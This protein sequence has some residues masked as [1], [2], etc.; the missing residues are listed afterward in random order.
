M[1]KLTTFL[2]TAFVCISAAFADI[3]IKVDI[4]D[5]NLGWN[6]VF[7][8]VG[9]TDKK[10]GDYFTPEPVEG[11]D[12][13]YSYTFTD[14]DVLTNLCFLDDK[15]LWIGSPAASRPHC[16]YFISEVVKST[17]YVVGHAAAPTA[18]RTCEEIDCGLPAEPKA[19]ITAPAKATVNKEITL[20]ATSADVTEPVYT[21]YVKTPEAEDFTALAA[22]TYTPAVTGTYTFKV[23]V[24]EVGASETILATSKE[25][26]V[27]VE[28]STDIVVTVDASVVGWSQVY[29]YRWVVGGGPGSFVEPENLGNG[30]Y[31]YTFTGNTEVGLVF[32]DNNTWAADSRQTVDVVGGITAGEHCFLINTAMSGGKRTVTKISCGEGPGVVLTLPAKIFEGDNL[33]LTANATNVDNPV[34]TYS[35]KA[36]GAADF[37]ALDGDSY[38]VAQTGSYTF[39]VA[40]AD[41]SAPSTIL[42]TEE[43]EVTVKEL[44]APITVT[45]DIS[46]VGW[47]DVHIYWWGDGEG[48]EF[49]TAQRIG[50]KYSYTF[51]RIETSVS[52]IFVNGSDWGAGQTVDIADIA[53][54]KH[55]YTID[56]AK[57]GEG[58]NTVTTAVCVEEPAIAVTAP[59][60]VYLDETITITAEA[61][62][63]TNPV[64]S[65]S[66]KAPGD[67]EFSPLESA[68][69]DYVPTVIGTYTFKITAA[70]AAAPTVII[71]TEEAVVEVREV[72]GDIKITVDI[73]ATDWTQA[74][75]YYWAGAANGFI[76]PTLEGNTYSYTFTRVEEVNI[77]FVD[78]TSW[79]ESPA[80]TVNIENVTASTCY[81]I[82][83]QDLSGDSET[84]PDYGK[85]AVSIT[86]CTPPVG[87]EVISNDIVL[88]N[89]DQKIEMSF[90]G[91]ADVRIYTVGGILVMSESADG[92]FSTPL[93]EGAYIVRINNEVCK[94]L[95]K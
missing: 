59:S 27:L 40:V 78:G 10:T 6:Q 69:T 36:P 92:W 72:P 76:T 87:I 79:D 41:N 1:K 61:I 42:A 25:T 66:M 75:I 71:I 91:R 73:S 33:T 31:T 82:G 17:C 21:Y 77:I 62:D 85:H 8:W 37:T 56:A 22:D 28:P 53:A 94:V 55:C 48:N 83:A 58:K 18:Y 54:G 63:M 24:A 89:S 11:E 93:R 43:K 86:E 5:S 74:A 4:S 3:T 57:D 51:T 90:A 81:I 23:T 67:S 14:L 13:V 39:K 64:L 45:A 70:E 46:A 30:I 84:N 7:L 50:D 88:I 95:V 52:V 68:P 29:F 80:Q 20:S 15:A 2:L 32:A 12:G 60:K 34:Y 19:F 26:E 44:P 47:S 38:A 9:A 49:A 35:V 65:Y 16:T